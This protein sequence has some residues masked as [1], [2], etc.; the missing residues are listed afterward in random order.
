MLIRIMFRRVLFRSVVSY[1]GKGALLALG[2]DLKIR[3]FTKKSEI[4]R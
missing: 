4:T 1:Y 3:A 2:L